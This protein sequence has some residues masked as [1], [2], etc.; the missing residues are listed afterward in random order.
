MPVVPA[1]SSPWLHGRFWPRF[2][3]DGGWYEQ[4]SRE[5]AVQL[6]ACVRYAGGGRAVVFTRVFNT[7]A[8]SA[9]VTPGRARMACVQAPGDGSDHDPQGPS[10]GKG[11]RMCV[12]ALGCVRMLASRRRDGARAEACCRGRG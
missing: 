9:V 10:E 1:G 8:T 6:R 4:R 2:P 3:Q 11:W 7:A 12:C 5:V